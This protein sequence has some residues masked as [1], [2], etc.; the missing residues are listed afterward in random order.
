MPWFAGVL[1][2]A[3][4]LVTGGRELYF[5]WPGARSYVGQLQVGRDG[6][7]LCAF[8]R[9]PVSPVPVEVRHCWTLGG[10]VI[11][12]TVVSAD[13]QSGRA[14]LF[15]DQFQTSAWRQLHQCLYVRRA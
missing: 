1:A 5:T 9:D 12:L 14:I 13:G 3:L 10:R 2:A 15:A 4:A 6:Q 11:G 8:G 7:L